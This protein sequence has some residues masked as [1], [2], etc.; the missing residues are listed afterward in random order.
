MMNRFLMARYHV[1][2]RQ[3]QRLEFWTVKKSSNGKL[4]FCL[5]FK[6]EIW[7]I[8]EWGNYIRIIFV[9]SFHNLKYWLGTPCMHVLLEINTLIDISQDVSH[10]TRN[11]LTRMLH[12]KGETR[13]MISRNA[14]LFCPSQSPAIGQVSAAAFHNIH[15]RRRRLQCGSLFQTFRKSSWSSWP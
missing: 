13:G 8:F 14:S 3:L 2:S 15:Q 7:D 5:P 11:T 6:F 1:T 12:G 10:E 4:I 9:S